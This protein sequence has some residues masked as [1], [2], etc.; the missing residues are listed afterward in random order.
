MDGKETGLC[1]RKALSREGR[2]IEVELTVDFSVIAAYC[3]H[4]KW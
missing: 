4:A 2:S 1:S 3:G